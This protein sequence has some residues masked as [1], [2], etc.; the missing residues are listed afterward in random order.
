MSI[1]GTRRIRALPLITRVT[2]PH[3]DNH[4]LCLYHH[5]LHHLHHLH[6]QQQLQ[7]SAHRLAW[8]K[9][10]ASVLLNKMVLQNESCREGGPLLQ[11]DES[12]LEIPLDLSVSSRAHTASPNHFELIEKEE[13][14]SK[15]P[16][17]YPLCKDGGK[18]A[19]LVGDLFNKTHPKNTIRL[20]PAEDIMKKE[21][22]NFDNEFEERKLSRENLMRSPLR[23]SVTS[24][25]VRE[26]RTDHNYN[27]D[28]IHEYIRRPRPLSP[29]AR[30]VIPRS[31]SP[32]VSIYT[33]P[34]FEQLSLKGENSKRLPSPIGFFQE[35]L[36]ETNKSA[37]KLYLAV[38]GGSDANY[39]QS[40]SL[41][42]APYCDRRSRSPSI[43]GDRAYSRSQSP[44]REQTYPSNMSPYNS[45]DYLY[46]RYPS[47]PPYSNDVGRPPTPDSSPR[48][49]TSESE[50]VYRPAVPSAAARKCYSDILTRSSLSPEIVEQKPTSLAN[51]GS[52]SDECSIN[53]TNSCSST[54][55]ST[56]L[57]REEIDI[58]YNKRIGCVSSASSPDE[59][60]EHSV[61]LESEEKAEL[62]RDYK[63]DLL[64]RFLHTDGSSS[65]D[66]RLHLP[67]GAPAASSLSASNPHHQL[68]S[69][70]P[71]HQQQHLRGRDQHQYRQQQQHATHQAPSIQELLR[72]AGAR[73]TSSSSSG[74]SSSSN[75]PISGYSNNSSNNNGPSNSHNNG[76]F[77]MNPAAHSGHRTT[78]HNSNGSLPPSPAD[79]GVSDVDS[80]SGQNLNDVCSSNTP[81]SPP[82]HTYGLHAS[83][84]R[85]H[86]S[87]PQM[88]HHHQQQQ[89]QQQQQQ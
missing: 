74:H 7:H 20:R 19:D 31:L 30:C 35:D 88:H 23:S 56:K 53:N 72:N 5:R 18:K 62:R 15:V 64:K 78:Y 51:N 38:T 33:P 43:Q 34:H 58:E 40:S 54:M 6:Q 27:E 48:M 52:S 86:L 37:S 32:R 85:M 21:Y 67:S 13:R 12:P 26:G 44:F 84:S 71:Q 42:A 81:D 22:I 79:S 69:Q 29:V 1:R 11:Y 3:L 73:N 8:A 57:T 87:H 16:P 46:R 65:T 9:R 24:Q 60:L 25:S 76:Y 63:K 2:H 49:D 55:K 82:S 83:S 10:E 47:P 14:Y 70:H 4:P 68:H 75:S 45:N 89:Q 41:R 50:V 39:L 66:G 77:A 17:L 61:S 36:I 80:S 28:S 59:F